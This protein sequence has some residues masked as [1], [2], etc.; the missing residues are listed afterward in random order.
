MLRSLQLQT[1]FT[2]WFHIIFFLDDDSIKPFKL[3]K[4]GKKFQEKNF[5]QK[6]H[7][8]AEAMEAEAIQKL[9]FPH[10]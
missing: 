4:S 7:Q 3:D 9:S 2:F 5:K 1:N 6:L 10:P 8:V